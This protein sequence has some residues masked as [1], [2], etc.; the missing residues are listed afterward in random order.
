M[1]YGRKMLAELGPNE[2]TTVES[3]SPYTAY[4]RFSKVIY[5]PGNRVECEFNKDWSCPFTDPW[6]LELRNDEGASVEMIL[7]DGSYVEAF[8]GLPRILPVPLCDPLIFFKTIKWKRITEKTPKRNFPQYLET[9]ERIILEKVP[10]SKNEIE[11]IRAELEQIALRKV[12]LTLK[13]RVEKSGLEEQK[14]P[15]PL[16]EKKE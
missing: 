16:T 8:R 14:V 4:A 3:Y 7:I 12:S 6:L 9:K 2:T 5:Q 13:R 1:E 11:G 10:R 15:Q